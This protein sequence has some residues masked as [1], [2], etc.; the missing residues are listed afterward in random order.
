MYQPNLKSVALPV[1]VLIGGSQKIRGGPWLCP[2]SLFPPKSYM[3]I[4]QTIHVCVLVFP[5]FDCSFG[6]V[7]R[8]SNLGGRDMVPSERPLVSSYR[9]SIVTFSLSLRVS[10][11]L[12]LSL[13]HL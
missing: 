4:M 9:P 12:P 5:R 8:T 3:H 13:P 10:K 7:L 2:H 11:I 1:H 6:W